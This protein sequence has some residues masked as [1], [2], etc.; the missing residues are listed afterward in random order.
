MSMTTALAVETTLMELYRS[1]DGPLLASVLNSVSTAEAGFALWYMQVRE[2]D[3]PG[4]LDT[5]TI[6]IQDFPQN[7]ELRKFLETHRSVESSAAASSSR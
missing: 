2:R 3:A 7:Q 1:E 5:A 4:A 6:L